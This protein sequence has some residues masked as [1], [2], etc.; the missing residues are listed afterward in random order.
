[1]VDALGGS[2]CAPPGW[3]A[4][5]SLLTHSLP[6]LKRVKEE[7]ADAVMGKLDA[8]LWETRNGAAAAAHAPVVDDSAMELLE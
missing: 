4:A 5:A 1:M 7:R 3:S 6:P 8:S 2:T